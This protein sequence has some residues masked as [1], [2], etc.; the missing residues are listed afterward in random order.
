MKGNDKYSSTKIC[1][2]CRSQTKNWERGK[3]GKKRISMAL[4]IGRGR[5]CYIPFA[6]I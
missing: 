6:T 4:N 1:N 5:N 3:R 2:E